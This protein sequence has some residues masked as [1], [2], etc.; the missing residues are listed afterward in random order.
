MKTKF[1]VIRHAILFTIPIFLF[2]RMQAEGVNQSVT[3]SGK[4]AE[5]SSGKPLPNAHIVLVKTGFS[6]HSDPLG[7]F[8]I[9]GLKP[10][11][12]IIK[13]SFVGFNTQ[14]RELLIQKDTILNF[15]M[16]GA[17]LLGEDVNIIATRAQEKTPA[18][19]STLSAKEITA[20]NLGKDM[21]YILQ[22]TPSVVVSSDAGN[23]IGYT[24]ISIRGTDL[25]RINVTINGVPLNDAESQGVWFVDLPDLASTTE[26]IQVQRGVG[27]STNGAGAFGATINMQTS[28]LKD[29]PYGEL[30]LSGGSFHTFKSTLLFGTGLMA[31][32]FSVDGRLSYIT[33]NGYIDR[34]FSNLKSYYV[35]AGF[36]GRST[37]LKLIAFSGFEK[38]YQA[39]EGVPKDSLSTNRTYNPA[40]QYYDQNGQIAYYE[41]QTDNY[42]QDHFQLIYSQSV[43]KNWN[44]NLALHYT[45]GK[46]YYE[47]YKQDE[48]F[49]DYG[50]N[51]V[52]IGADTITETDLVNRKFLNN[53]YYG[54]IFSTNYSIPKKLKII[55][56]GAWSRYYGKHYGKIIWAEYSS[57]GNNERDWYYNTGLKKDFNVFIKI[58]YSIFQKLNLYT[59]LQYRYVG[60]EMNGVLDDLRSLDQDHKF[61]FFNPKAGVFYSNRNQKAYFSFGMAHREP[62]RN[63]YKDADPEN[64]PTYETLYDYELG[65][66]FEIPNLMVKANLYYMYYHN[67]LVLTGEINNV[68]EA[69]M[70]NVP[71]SY[72]AGIEIMAG[73]TFL[74]KLQ[75]NINAT[76]SRN[77][78]K[79]FTEFIDDYDSTAQRAFQLGETNLS[80]SP[81]VILGSVLTYK[82]IRNLSISLNSRY[83]GKQFIDNTSNPDHSLDPY[84]IN[85]LTAGYSFVL[86]PFREI[87]F[88]LSLNNIFGV[89]YETNGW[90][91]QYFSGNQRYEVNGYFPQSMFGFLFGITL[92]I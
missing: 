40:G 19:F 29:E 39:W 23:G 45:K 50:L 13:V 31:N 18:T 9:Q 59:D 57:N 55:L 22:S 30:N 24:G 77:R 6:T 86:N 67:Q 68:G 66:D 32:K 16:E 54:L 37:T 83:I 80:F 42:Q 48:L 69:V 25:T 11:K 92:K 61:D 73:V 85:G 65:Y 90:V 74:K 47:N 58:N 7:N 21:P 52:I 27:T 56:G 28:V 76:F 5:K 35:S 44:F 49:T 70:V 8:I 1:S 51:N 89:K 87:G 26:N 12:F 81:G 2:I 10:G 17:I 38:T 43:L 20:Q 60:Y 33:S 4:I 36:F 91:Y 82:P 3:I 88:N 46:G 79:N 15:Q 78:I 63:N 53:D 34:A 84:F 64:M 41:N 62:S 75:W 72:R 71:S 14:S